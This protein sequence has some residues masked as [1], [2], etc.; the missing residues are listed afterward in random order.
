MENF[1]LNLTYVIAYEHYM[2]VVLFFMC[3]REW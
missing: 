3:F 2:N 1:S